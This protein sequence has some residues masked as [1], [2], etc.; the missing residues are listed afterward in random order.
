M[1]VVGKR[2]CV[3]RAASKTILR[4]RS[5]AARNDEVVQ[6]DEEIGGVPLGK[7][8]HTGWRVTYELSRTVT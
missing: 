8:S 7:P 6:K 3:G 5:L 4:V 1:V 2:G